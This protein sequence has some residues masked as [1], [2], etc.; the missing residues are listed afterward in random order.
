MCVCMMDL[1]INGFIIVANKTHHPIINKMKIKSYKNVIRQKN[2]YSFMLFLLI[3]Y[4]IK[5]THSK[6]LFPMK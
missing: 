2:N 4:L 5:I 3:C 1:H 6:F